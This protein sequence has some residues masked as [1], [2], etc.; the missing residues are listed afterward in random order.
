MTGESTNPPLPEIS[1]P[2]VAASG[3]RQWLRTT[4]NFFLVIGFS[5]LVLLPL[6]ERVLRTFFNT[7]IL[8]VY[9]FVLHFSLFIGM[10]GGAIAARDGRLLSIS[11]LSIFLKGNWKVGARIASHSFSAT[12]SFFLLVASLSF[13]NTEIDAGTTFAY[14]IA[15][16]VLQLVMPLGFTA[17]TLRLIWNSADCWKGK[18][19]SLAMV[20]AT[21]LLLR[22]SPV[23]PE[24]LFWPAIIL[25]LLATLLGAPI[26][27]ALG[28]L[29]LIYFWSQDLPIS[30]ISVSHYSLVLE[31]MVPTIP[32]FTLAGYFLAESKASQRLIRVFQALVGQ[33][34]AGP[35]FVTVLVCAFFTTF[36]G[37]SGVT[38]LALGGL[39]MPVL[40][41]A[42]Y[43][44]RSA[45]GLLTG[46]GSLGLLFPPCLP[47]ILYFIVAN[48]NA[49]GSMDLKQ[50]FLGGITPGLL[51]IAM[52]TAW[53]GLANTRWF[54]IRSKRFTR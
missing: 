36:T 8:G 53:G 25:L 15:S 33:F 14:G 35:T 46:A 17:I 30:I 34:R 24:K 7:G 44:E 6:T 18:T 13:I 5:L 37:A 12:V 28:G 42:R 29:T 39:L 51:L 48:S 41:A 10:V 4:E 19:I 3:W 40:L 22:W 23:P 1:E 49:Q 47:L 2:I 31:S 50:M 26:F 54:Q 27:S 20:S 16:W 32:L 11:T 38:I 45:I 52:A 9:D 43:N 21:I